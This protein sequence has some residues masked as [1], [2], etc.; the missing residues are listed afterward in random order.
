M[1]SIFNADNNAEMINRIN[2]LTVT[3]PAQWGKM[4]AA[5]M[6]AHC[7]ASMSIGFGLSKCHRHWV[8]VLFGNF[9]KKRMLKVFEFDRHMPA[10]FK[11]RI[12]DDR[13]FE[14][15]KH[16]IIT[17]IKLALEKGEAGLVKYPHPYFG[18]F[19]SGEWTQLNWRHLDHHLRQFGV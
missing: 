4:D 19:K 6:M 3:T 17:I 14:Q 18:K 13:D 15:E 12:T 2:Q 10:Y 16:K 7:Y 11:L 1:K 5:Q 8:G 9:A